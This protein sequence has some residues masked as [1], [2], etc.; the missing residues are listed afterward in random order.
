MGLWGI[1]NPHF[2]NDPRKNAKRAFVKNWLDN[3]EPPEEHPFDILQDSDSE[4]ESESELEQYPSLVMRRI[5]LSNVSFSPWRNA[6]DSA[7]QSSTPYSYAAP[8]GRP[9]YSY[10]RR[11]EPVP[12][13]TWNEDGVIQEDESEEESDEESDDEVEDDDDEEVGK[14]LVAVTNFRTCAD[15]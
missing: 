3:I 7:L 14:Y 5:D 4:S 12:Y 10:S 11:L 9:A 6:E 15:W 8:A 2:N 13:P 1:L